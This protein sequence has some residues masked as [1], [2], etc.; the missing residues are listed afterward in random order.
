MSSQLLDNSQ[1][2]HLEVAR[3]KALELFSSAE[4]RV[5]GDLLAVAAWRT[6]QRDAVILPPHH[7][8][9]V[10]GIVVDGKMHLLRTSDAGRVLIERELGPGE[11]FD[12]GRMSGVATDEPSGEGVAA[13]TTICF[14]P[15]P[16]LS[17]AL[18]STPRSAS[19]FMGHL[20]DVRR[21]LGESMA[22]AVLHDVPT[23]VRHILRSLAE[24]NQHH[25]VPHTSTEIAALAGVSREQ[26]SRVIGD[27]QRRGL[28]H[29]GKGRGLVISEPGALL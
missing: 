20:R 5:L 18:A 6:Y 16:A 25:L 22:D 12:F 3:L 8:A 23:H 7:N 4:D 1:R 19:V 9:D 21:Q 17:R 28:V 15:W 26:A 27:L 13:P 10:E 29:K 2:R 24:E 11:T 14:L